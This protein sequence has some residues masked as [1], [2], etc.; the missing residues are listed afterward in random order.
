SNDGS[1]DSKS[2]D[3]SSGSGSDNGNSNTRP[4][5][6]SSTPSLDDGNSDTN[7]DNGSLTPGLDDGNSDTNPDNKSSAPSSDSGDSGKGNSDAS[8]GDSGTK[9][10]DT[11][12]SDTKTSDTAGSSATK[13]SD[14]GSSDAKNSNTVSSNSGNSDTSNSNN[15]SSDTKSPDKESSDNKSADN[16]SSDTENEN[17]NSSSGSGMSL[18]SSEPATNIAAKELS[19]RSIISGYPVQFDFTKNATCIVQIEFDPKKTFR[20]TTTVV[21]E[22]K[23]RSTL[24]P[25]S[26]EGTIY[27]YVNI[28][29]GENGAGLP[30][31]IKSGFVEFKV[32]KAWIKDN[33]ISESQIVLQRYD[34]NWQPL[35]TEKIGE[36]KNYIYFKSET[37]GY[38]FFA[39]TEYTGQKITKISGAENIQETLKNLGSEGRA[40]LY[41]NAEKGN[42]KIKNP[43]GAARIF[44]AIS[45][46]L[47]MLIVG[48]CISK[49]KI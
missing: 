25:T 33:N 12:H 39:I 15:T 7:P 43:M 1:S 5:D 45:L 36:D 28:W 47:F 19:T 27:K 9:T 49:K 18:V 4:D 14:T 41:G 24:V 42:G 34:S 20:K 46:P 31:S 23:N 17:S 48:Y 22:L 37:P 35:Y 2:N 16:G 29:V 21:E 44:M 38:S 32:E 3:G 8:S 26:P 40:A 6:G 13:T 10:S 30:T 11:G